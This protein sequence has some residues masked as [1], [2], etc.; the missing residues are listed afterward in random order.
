MTTQGFCSSLAVLGSA[1]QKVGEGRRGNMR[2][3]V[4]LSYHLSGSRVTCVCT[5]KE[6]YMFKAS[7]KPESRNSGLSVPVPAEGLAKSLLWGSAPWELRGMFAL[8]STEKLPVSQHLS[9]SVGTT[10]SAGC[11]TS[12]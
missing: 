7:P 6:K 2:L 12:L 1:R 5:Q 3:D 8:L 10:L 11:R 4:S 9:F